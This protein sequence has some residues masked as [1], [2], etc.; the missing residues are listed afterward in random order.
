MRLPAR[1]GEEASMSGWRMA[2]TMGVGIMGIS[3]AVA[4]LAPGS[5][6][7]GGSALPRMIR[8]LMGQ[9]VDDPE[10]RGSSGLAPGEALLFNGWGITP[11]GRHVP[12]TDLPLK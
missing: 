9:S 11:A 5:P 2:R 6:V 8:R 7:R 4:L 3:A 10:L 12:T 1:A